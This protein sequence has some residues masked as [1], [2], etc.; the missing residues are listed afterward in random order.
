MGYKV[1]SN[2]HWSNSA[3]AKGCFWKM[4]PT[5]GITRYHLFLVIEDSMGYMKSVVVVKINLVPYIVN[6][7][8]FDH[9]N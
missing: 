5:G 2:N 7:W 1:T 4:T 8:L 3:V 9:N 6:G